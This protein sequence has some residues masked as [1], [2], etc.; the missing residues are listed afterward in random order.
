MSVE[1]NKQDGHEQNPVRK[2]PDDYLFLKSCFDQN[3]KM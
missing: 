1:R 2:K 3:L